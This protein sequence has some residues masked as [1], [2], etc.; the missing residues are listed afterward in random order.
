MGLMMLG[1][2]G[3]QIQSG[4]S[5]GGRSPIGIG[6]AVAVHALVVGA[7]L[8]IPKEAIAP[9]VPPILLG[10]PI[11]LDPP[12]PPEPTQPQEAQVP[13]RP[14]ADPRPTATDPR[15]VLP[16]VGGETLTGGDLGGEGIGTGDII[17]PPLDPPRDPVLVEPRIDP[18]ALA[19]FQPD[20]PGSMVRQGLEGSVTV[21]VTIGADGRV[22]G[23]ERVSATDEAFW[24]VTQRH[25]LRKWRFR[26]ATRDGVAV[27]SS[28]TLTVHFR[29]T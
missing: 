23:I 21:R 7:F 19:A 5:G 17:L 14:V 26:P 18:R 13:T 28:K 4:Y 8:L 22:T 29:L 15:V 12:P 11:P 16:P 10:R 9:Y 1:A 6:G 25:A 20:Y 2:A 24:I 27:E 3:G